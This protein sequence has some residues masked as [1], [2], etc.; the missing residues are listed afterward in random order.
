[1]RCARLAALF[2]LALVPG[3]AGAGPA[4]PCDARFLVQGEPLLGDAPEVVDVGSDGVS[5]ADHCGERK[6]RVRLTPEGAR[7][8]VRFSTFCPPGLRCFTP[9]S[10]FPGTIEGIVVGPRR[11]NHC[12]DMRG[13]RLQATL[14]PSCQVLTGRLR[15]RQPRIDR[16]FVAAVRAL[17]PPDCVPNAAGSHCLCGSLLGVGCAEGAFCQV[18]ADSCGEEGEIGSCVPVPAECGDPQQPVCGCDGVSYANDC[19]RRAAAVSKAHDGACESP[20]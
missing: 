9:S 16:E 6:A 12:S 18:S 3:D 17:V 14:D 8:R 4:P 13:V 5:I 20:E 19:A 1:M 15:A 7:L 2:V 11:I 10:D